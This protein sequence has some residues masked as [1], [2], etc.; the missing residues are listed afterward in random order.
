MRALLIL[1]VGSS[2]LACNDGSSLPDLPK[3]QPTKQRAPEPVA[4]ETTPEP[5]AKKV[6]LSIGEGFEMRRPIVDGKLTVIPIIATKAMST[7]KF[8]SLHD[9]MAKNLVYVRE[10]GGVDTWDVDYVRITNNSKETL[11]ILE[12]ELIEDAMQ[13][14]ITAE[15]TTIL[16]GATK[17]V[18]VRCVEEDRSDGGIKFNPG[19]A[20]AE[21]SLRR[22]LVHRNQDAIWAKVK[23]INAREKLSN[24]TNTY[25]HAAKA[26]LRGENAARRGRILKALDS[27]EERPNIVGFAI[28]VDGQVMAIERFANAD[29]YKAYESK[30]LASYLPTTG[31]D[32]AVSEKKLSPDDIRKL[33][34]Q[35]R[36][37]RTE[38]SFTVIHAL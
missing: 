19:H 12:G 26:Q 38:A 20:L 25:R 28:A 7:Q 33:A 27:M 6:D 34:T 2:L 8:I 31:G 15:A 14:R 18:G 30:L 1:A 4:K 13:D 10:L 21:L 3:P 9:G 22:V 23:V 29:V 37:S 5:V 36:A 35:P 16:A 17:Q 24:G 32:A 11:V